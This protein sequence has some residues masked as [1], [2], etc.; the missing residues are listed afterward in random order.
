MKEKPCTSLSSLSSFDRARRVQATARRTQSAVDMI[1]DGSAA[2]VNGESISI[3][4]AIPR[5]TLDGPTPF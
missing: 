1:A 5:P 4:L 3:Q 2:C